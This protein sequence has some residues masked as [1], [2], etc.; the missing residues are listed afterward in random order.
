MFPVNC[1][2]NLNTTFH[3]LMQSPLQSHIGLLRRHIPAWNLLPGQ[4]IRHCMRSKNFV[5]F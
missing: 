2:T 3:K 4:A 1:K 5:A